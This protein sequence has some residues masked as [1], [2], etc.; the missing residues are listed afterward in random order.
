MRL[1]FVVVATLLLNVSYAELFALAE[2]DLSEVTGRAGITVETVTSGDI[3]VFYLDVDSATDKTGGAVKLEGVRVVKTGAGGE[4]TSV[5]APII[6]E[7]DIVEGGGSGERA[8]RLKTSFA[9]NSAIKI[10]AIRFASTGQYSS[11]TNS[12]ST[13]NEGFRYVLPNVTGCAAG[14]ASTSAAV[15]LGKVNITGLAGSASVSIRGH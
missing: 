9:A 8:V 7:I 1:F 14:C 5:S 11:G 12:Y 15:S 3:N 4:L 13:T 6:T 2:G 10:D